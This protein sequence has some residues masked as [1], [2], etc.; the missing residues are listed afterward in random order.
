MK[1]LM[2]HC[3]TGEDAAGLPYE[4]SYYML[5][6]R[7]GFL[8][9]YGVEITMERGQEVTC[10]NRAMVTPIAATMIDMIAR[11]AKNHVTPITLDEVLSEML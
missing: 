1:R 2:M 10:G 11:L 8:E 9:Q 6:E 7:S 5:I 3:C 4:L